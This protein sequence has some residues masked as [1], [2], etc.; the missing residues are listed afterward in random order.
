[1]NPMRPGAVW[2]AAVVACF[3]ASPMPAAACKFVLPQPV[4][5]TDDTPPRAKKPKAPKVRVEAITRGSDA[6]H[7]CASSGVVRLAIDTTPRNAD[8]VY[9]FRVIRGDGHHAFPAGALEGSRDGGTV[10]FV[11]PFDDGATASQEP[12]DFVVRVTAITRA[13]RKGAHRDVV[14]RD[15]GRP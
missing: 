14:V 10:R 11:F 1:M 5:F 8:A 2:L 9:A 13:G 3:A 7:S 6:G 15:P 12:L 4:A